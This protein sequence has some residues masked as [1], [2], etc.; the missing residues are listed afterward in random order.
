[1]VHCVILSSFHF[2]GKCAYLATPKDE[3]V[4]IAMTKTWFDVMPIDA[5]SDDGYQHIHE[6]RKWYDD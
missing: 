2:I 5:Y 1:M 6:N 3:F 4:I